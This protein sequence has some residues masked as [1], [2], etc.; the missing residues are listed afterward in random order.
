M[1]V[2][3]KKGEEK[4][5]LRGRRR[6]RRKNIKKKKKWLFLSL[7]EGLLPEGNEI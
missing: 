4:Y 7:V 1:M 6:R 5:D 2:I 3:I